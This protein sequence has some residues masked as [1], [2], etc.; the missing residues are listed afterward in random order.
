MRPAG[1]RRGFRIVFRWVRPRAGFPPATVICPFG[2]AGGV[3]LN[4]GYPELW[5]KEWPDLRPANPT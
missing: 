1:A 2:T 5:K 3:I 4:V